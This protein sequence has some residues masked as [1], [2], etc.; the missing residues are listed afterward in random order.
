MAFICQHQSAN[1]RKPPHRAQRDYSHVA[2]LVSSWGYG[3]DAR[4]GCTQHR[5]LIVPVG[6]ANIDAEV[7]RVVFRQGEVRAVQSRLFKV[8]TLA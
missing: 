7:A 6:G 5:K 2:M 1:I 3:K 4:T 8:L